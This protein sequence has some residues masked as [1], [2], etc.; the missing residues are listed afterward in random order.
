MIRTILGWL[1]AAVLIFGVASWLA[2]P[3]NG[4][5][6]GNTGGDV[7]STGVDA[8]GGAGD[9]LTGIVNGLTN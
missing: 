4:R 3:G 1:V 6:L 9:V 8:V 2:E 7:A 5:R